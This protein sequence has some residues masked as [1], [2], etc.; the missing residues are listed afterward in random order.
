VRPLATA[1]AGL[2]NAG[3]SVADHL[4]VPPDIGVTEPVGDAAGDQEGVA[5]LE[6]DL[7]ELPVVEIGLTLHLGGR[8]VD[9]PAGLGSGVGASV[10]FAY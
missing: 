6:E 1:V 7:R 9:Q 4:G 10:R 3:R 8:G 2:T 5:G